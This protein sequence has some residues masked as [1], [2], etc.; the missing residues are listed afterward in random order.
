M[1]TLMVGATG[2]LGGLIA[3]R[4]LQQDTG[5]VRVLVRP[6]SG[7]QALIDAGAEPAFGDLKDGVSLHRACAD[8]QTVITTANS[9]QRGGPDTPETV[10]LHGN[11][12]LIEAARSAGVRQFIFTS[13]LGADPNSP[14]PFMSA[15]GQ[16][17][18]TLRAS[19][20]PYTILAPNLFMEVWLGMVIGMPVQHGQPVILVGEG[21]RQHSLISVHDVAAF[22]VAAVGH[23]AAINQYLPLGGPTPVSFA[24]AVRVLEHV[25]GRTIP[26]KSIAPGEP[27]PGVPET[28][29][30]LYWMTE[31]YDSPV[32]MDSTAH[33]FGV[34]QTSFEDYLRRTFQ[35]VAA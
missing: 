19:G 3:R 33:R 9:A 13:A 8:V 1:T 12:N 32:P 5:P 2:Q 17:E 16:T 22:A 24:E 25:L 18:V 15:K 10:D 29:Q 23:P 6:S 14:M 35:S 4:L 21:C 7:Y 34:H 31:S 11:R 30:P 28:V 26:V 20:L 27:V